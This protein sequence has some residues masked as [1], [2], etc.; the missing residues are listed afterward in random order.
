[1]ADI[2]KILF[3]DFETTSKTD[4]VVD[5]FDRYLNDPAT[6]AY[7]FTYALPGMDKAE[8]WTESQPVPRRVIEHIADRKR[9]AAHNAQFDFNIWN[10]VLRRDRPELPEIKLEQV[11]CTAATARY[12]GL[13][14][15]L[16]NACKAINLPIQK[17][18]D[19]SKIM[20]Q[21]ATHPEWTEQT[22]PELFARI[23]K[24]ALTD[25]DAMIAL[26]RELQPLPAHEQAFYRLD[27]V[28]NMR[29]F[30]VD[31]EGAQ[32]MENLKALA[33][34]QLDYQIVIATAGKVGAVS[35]IA[36]IKEHIGAFDVDLDD[37]GKETVK[38]YL[39]QPDV[40]ADVRA[41]LELRLDASRAPKK[42]SAILRA[43]VGGRMRYTTV[44]HGALSGRSTARGAGGLQALNFS[45]PRPGRSAEDCEGYLEAAKRGDTVSLSSGKAAPLLAALAD[46]QRSLVVAGDG[47]LYVG[48]DLSGIEARMAPWLANDEP[49]LVDYENGIDS[50]KRAATT[51]Y[52]N[53]YEEVT[54]DQRQIGKVCLAGDTEVLT[55]A[56]W[57]FIIDVTPNDLL[58]DGEEWVAHAGLVDNGHAETVD[59]DGVQCTPDHQFWTGTEW[60][61]Q[62]N[63]S[64][65][66]LALVLATSAANLP[67][68]VTSG[69]AESNI[70]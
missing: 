42:S 39:A 8:L 10:I 62:D 24:Y 28:I 30:G 18:M 57:K 40:P 5:G 60:V 16:E 55:S 67:P 21:V 7:C 20:M 23:Y 69:E 47:K 29:G 45:R 63:M 2:S 68:L 15:S 56:G 26:Y 12:N 48:A 61:T 50:Y 32:A 37:A 70:D 66:H 38:K 6:R 1:M 44:Y 9:F 31:V 59:M 11:I 25:T 53:E 49:K 36:K 51:V 65:S 14:G 22:H 46:A 64:A 27:Q 35:E 19:G 4:L 17:D 41:V 13:P 54:K 34:A 58:W 43:H 3:L 52:G 33:Q